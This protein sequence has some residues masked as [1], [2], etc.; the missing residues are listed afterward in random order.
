MADQQFEDKEQVEIEGTKLKVPGKRGFLG[1]G[2]QQNIYE[3]SIKKP[4]LSIVEIDFKV[5][6][7]INI[8]IKKIPSKKDLINSLDKLIHQTSAQWLDLDKPLPVTLYYLLVVNDQ[9]KPFIV[10][11]KLSNIFDKPY[12]D[13]PH[14]AAA[15]LNKA[16]AEEKVGKFRNAVKSFRNFINVAPSQYASH[17][18]YAQRRIHELT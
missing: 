2:R 12:K 14:Y 16:S 3:I 17:V 18:E 1:M 8:T 7:K 13:N 6:A 5:K 11:K 9:T 15:W 10:L 4:S